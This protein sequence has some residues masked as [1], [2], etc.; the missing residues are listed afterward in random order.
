MLHAAHMLSKSRLHFLFPCYV[1]S[2]CLFHQ[3]K[4]FVCMWSAVLVTCVDEGV[5][6]VSCALPCLP[7]SRPHPHLGNALGVSSAGAGM[8]HSQL[9]A[10][11]HKVPWVP[12]CEGLLV[13][14][15]LLHTLLAWSRSIGLEPVE[16][17]SLLIGEWG[18]LARGELVTSMSG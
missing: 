18:L 1:L 6:V 16:L 11:L 2:V 8:G 17:A 5:F 4:W 13:S 7:S 12:C 14:S 10:L 9:M 15:C 3:G